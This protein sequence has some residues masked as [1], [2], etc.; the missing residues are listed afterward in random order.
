MSNRVFSSLCTYGRIL[1]DTIILCSASSSRSFESGRGLVKKPRDRGLQYGG[2]GFI[3]S[4]LGARS[5]FHA[6]AKVCVI[7]YAVTIAEDCEVR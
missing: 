2:S 3:V 5:S 6:V 4:Y 1:H 7:M